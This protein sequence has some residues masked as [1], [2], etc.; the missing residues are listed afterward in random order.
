M[1]A[2]VTHCVTG[3]PVALPTKLLRSLKIAQAAPGSVERC[4]TPKGIPRKDIS[5]S[6]KF[7][8]KRN[9]KFSNSGYEFY[10]F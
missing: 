5:N 9:S 1:T 10:I 4:G 2:R 6:I 8:V 7:F 3:Y